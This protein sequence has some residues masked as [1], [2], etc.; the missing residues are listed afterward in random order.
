[1]LIIEGSSGWRKKVFIILHAV[2]FCEM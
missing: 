2:Q 1:L